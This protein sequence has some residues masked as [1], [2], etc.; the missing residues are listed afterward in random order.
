MK[1]QISLLRLFNLILRVEFLFFC[2]FGRRFRLEKDKRR[3]ML[4]HGKVTALLHER[5]MIHRVK[6]G[7]AF[8]IL[9]MHFALR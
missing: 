5:F 1:I 4:N 9:V 7:N 8:K 3:V 2:I 6:K